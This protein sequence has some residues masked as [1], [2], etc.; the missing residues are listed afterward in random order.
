MNKKALKRLLIG[1]FSVKR[2]VRS[3]ILIYGLVALWA[4]FDSDR[5]IFQPQPSSYQ[6]SNEFVK[7]TVAN[8]AKITGWYLPNPQAQYTILYSHGNAEDLGNIQFRLR[9]L[10]GLGFAVFAYDYQGYG[11]S[12]GKPSTQ[13]A[14]QDINAAY[15]YLTGPLKIP[16]GQIIVY[17]RSVGGGPSV[18]LASREPVAGLVTE[19][20][21]TTA[22]RVVT[23]VPVFP[24]DKFRNLDKISQV[25]SPILIMH[26]RGDQV[27][28]FSHSEQLFEVAQEPKRFFEVKDA[29]HNDFVE[30]AGPKYDQ[31]MIQFVELIDQNRSAQVTPN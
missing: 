9:Q 7:L 25:Q 19:S 23:R 14:Y 3:A 27:I 31:I 2:V 30:V 4:F 13:G 8:G 29:N 16:P 24:F 1:D 17:G 26:G 15:Q 5:L 28:P 21:F 18:D 6:D 20:T 11:T 12:E 10:Q 22:F